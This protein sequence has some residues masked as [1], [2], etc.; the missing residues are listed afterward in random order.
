[1]TAFFRWCAAPFVGAGNVEIAGLVL[2]LALSYLALALI[3]VRIEVLFVMLDYI[4][5]GLK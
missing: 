4:N 3:A 5:R 1:M 2:L